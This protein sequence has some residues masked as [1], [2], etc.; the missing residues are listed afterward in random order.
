M[1]TRLLINVMAIDTE[2][3]EFEPV[4]KSNKEG[5]YELDTKK[6]WWYPAIGFR[7]VRKFI[8]NGK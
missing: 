1:S 2:V 6:K 4:I 3:T 7:F 5:V 8:I